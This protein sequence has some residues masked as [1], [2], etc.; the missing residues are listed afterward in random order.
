MKKIFIL[1]Q[2]EKIVLYGIR[3]DLDDIEKLLLKKKI[4]VKCYSDNDKLSVL[5]NDN[6]EEMK[7]K[8][9][10]NDQFKIRSSEISFKK[11]DRKKYFTNFKTL[12]E[13]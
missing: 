11:I 5:L 13:K 10:L 7:I 8:D 6:D 9:I 3:F 12:N 1:Y 2:V 4:N